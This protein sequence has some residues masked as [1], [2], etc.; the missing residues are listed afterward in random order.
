MSAKSKAPK[1]TLLSGLAETRAAILVAAAQV[2]PRARD[3]VFLGVWSLRDLLAHLAGW[4]VTNLEAA[5]DIRA[6]RL[7]AFYAHH[8][9]G[10]KSYNAGLVAKYR[11]ED[12]NELLALVRD[13]HRRLIAYLES[14]PEEAF[15]RDFGVR[16]PRGF[17]VTIARL[18]RA[19]WQ[20]EVEHLKQIQGF[21]EK[22]D[23]EKG[24]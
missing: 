17:K 22:L 8:D 16:S 5:K 23:K 1:S 4:D 15:E 14:L 3:T 12:F 11:R 9:K 2:P 20:D 24:N 7:P 13:S 10:W 21:R 6:G 18:L 19:E